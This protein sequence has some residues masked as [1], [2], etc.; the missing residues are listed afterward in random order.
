M[1]FKAYK[2]YTEALNKPYTFEQV[3]NSPRANDFS[4]E[5]DKGIWYDVQMPNY[6]DDDGKLYTELMFY[7]TDN[8]SMSMQN[9]GD[10]FRVM[11]TI[12]DIVKKQKNFLQSRE[13][14][15]FT[16]D[17]RDSGRVKLYRRLAKIF[18]KTLGFKTVQEETKTGGVLFKVMKK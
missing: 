18:I 14:L 10:A 6:T 13:Y 16:A 9:T 8:E 12:V 15:E 3:S 5:T 2:A 7:Q 17:K 1:R 11:A 4:F